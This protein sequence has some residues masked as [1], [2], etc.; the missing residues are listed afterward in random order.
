MVR[1]KEKK[2][3]SNDHYGYASVT[4]KECNL[5]LKITITVFLFKVP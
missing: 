3:C 4:K 1:P 2:I 5:V